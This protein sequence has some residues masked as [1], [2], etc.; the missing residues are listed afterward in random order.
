[1]MTTRTP[2]T[3]IAATIQMIQRMTDLLRS[4]A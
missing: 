3:A 4:P 1:M 2:A